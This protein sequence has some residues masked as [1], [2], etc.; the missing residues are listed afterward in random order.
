MRPLFEAALRLYARRAPRESA[1][2]TR[3]PQLA[4]SGPRQTINLSNRLVALAKDN[5]QEC[6]MD[7]QTPTGFLA[8]IDS[9]HLDRDRLVSMAN[10]VAFGL[11]PKD[12]TALLESDR[13]A[14]LQEIIAVLAPDA[15]WAN[16]ATAYWLGDGFQASRSHYVAAVRDRV[17][18]ETGM[19]PQPQPYVFEETLEGDQLTLTTSLVMEASQLAVAG[20]KGKKDPELTECLSRATAPDALLADP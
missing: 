8:D 18:R 9:K 17:F 4:T 7:A 14:L 1:T 12:P 6:H 16:N 13:R 5:C 11:M 15:I 19:E 10:L 2:P 20:C 3:P